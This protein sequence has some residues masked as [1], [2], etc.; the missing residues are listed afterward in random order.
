MATNNNVET[1]V[2]ASLAGIKRQLSQLW[3][4]CVALSA[5]GGRETVR[6]TERE[7]V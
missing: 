6:E 2:D 5:E 1:D 4:C 7:A 3:S